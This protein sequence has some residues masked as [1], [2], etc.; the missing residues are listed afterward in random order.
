[1]LLLCV[2]TQETPHCL[3]TLERYFGETFSNVFKTI[4]FDNG[5]E[6]SDWESMERS[7]LKDEKRT[8]IYYAHPYCSSERGSNENCNGLLRRAGFKKSS[9]LGSIKPEEAVKFI[10]WVNSLPRRILGFQSALEAF[11]ADYRSVYGVTK[12]SSFQEVPQ[13]YATG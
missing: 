5:S 11:S 7:C 12:I 1:M 10:S 2:L 8:H 6:F 9:N 4:T 13:L 3:D